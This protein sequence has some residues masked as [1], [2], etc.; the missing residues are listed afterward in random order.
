MK[1]EI[2]QQY[3]TN[4]KLAKWQAMVVRPQKKCVSN[5][6]LLDEMKKLTSETAVRSTNY[7]IYI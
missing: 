5:K 7:R 1:D 6:K 4:I 3:F 2:L